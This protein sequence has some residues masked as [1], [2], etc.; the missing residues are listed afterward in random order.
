[1]SV[2]RSMP[3]TVSAPPLASEWQPRS[4]SVATGG[5]VPLFSDEQ[6]R[7]EHNV[8]RVYSVREEAVA[9][10]GGADAVV[11]LL[12]E[13]PSYLATFSKCL[14][15]SEDNR[16]FPIDW[17]AALLLDPE[18]ATV[19][20]H[21]YAAIAGLQAVISE[22]EEDAPAEE[23]GVAAVEVLRDLERAGINTRDLLTR[24]LGRKPGSVR[25]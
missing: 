13:R 2:S 16:R 19:L 17:D 23:K 15:R 20:I 7:R 22:R 12:N 10:A 8:S 24:K 1:M 5:Q 18:P 14:N 25:L 11:A 4:R 9:K 21:G 6:V 3:R